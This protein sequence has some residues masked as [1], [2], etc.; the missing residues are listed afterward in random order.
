MPTLLEGPPTSRIAPR[1][2]HINVQSVTLQDLPK[3]RVS[4]VEKFEGLHV[5]RKAPELL[6][7]NVETVSLQNY[8]KALLNSVELFEGS[9]TSRKAPGRQFNG[10][11]II[12][13]IF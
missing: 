4:S 6:N 1:L 7:V 13:A 2:L 10:I 5:P 8:S 3:E 12:W 11:Q 9:P